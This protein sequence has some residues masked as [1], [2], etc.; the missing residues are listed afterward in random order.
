MAKKFGAGHVINISERDEMDLLP[1][2][3]HSHCRT[4]SMA[5]LKFAGNRVSFRSG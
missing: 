3:E 2:F 4:V 5:S 1:T